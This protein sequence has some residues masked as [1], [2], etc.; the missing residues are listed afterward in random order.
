MQA[1]EGTAFSSERKGVDV[2]C[3]NDSAQCPAEKP[4]CDWTV[5]TGQCPPN[6]DE[7]KP[8]GRC[9]ETSGDFP[10]RGP[11]LPD[12]DEAPLFWFG[13][14]ALLGLA[15]HRTFRRHS[16]SPVRHPPCQ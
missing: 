10:L 4:F 2:L 12:P 15:L 16:A 14:G 11:V 5:R 8:T 6:V 9:V 1:S 3:C 13:L 7:A